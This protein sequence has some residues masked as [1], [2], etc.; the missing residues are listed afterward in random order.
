[1][2]AELAAVAVEDLD[3]VVLGRVVRGRASAAEAERHER[4]RA[5]RQHAAEHRVP[6]RRRDPAR[7][8]VLELG[9]GGARVAADEDAPAAGPERRPAPEAPPAPPSRSTSSGVSSS[10]TIPRTP[11]VP[12]YLL[13][14]AARL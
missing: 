1:M 14:I 7:E 13:A 6:V 5:R 4:S 8:R 2:V 10:P 11:S 9:P 12:K 3:A